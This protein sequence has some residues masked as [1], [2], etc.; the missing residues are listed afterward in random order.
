MLSQRQA[1]RDRDNFRKRLITSP[2]PD[3]GGRRCSEIGSWPIPDRQRRGELTNQLLD[4]G[5][6]SR[7]ASDRAYETVQEERRRTGEIF[8]F[9]EQHPDPDTFPSFKELIDPRDYLP[10]PA[11]SRPPG[12]PTWG[13][14]K[15]IRVVELAQLTPSQQ[16][17]DPVIKVAA[18][19]WDQ[20]YQ[21]FEGGYTSTRC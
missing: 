20:W 11:P 18:E 10:K 3:D 8:L 1:A 7:E 13:V 12:H 4:E 17:N 2:P 9:I 15:S 16:A 21:G 19:G 14:T 5:L 6:D